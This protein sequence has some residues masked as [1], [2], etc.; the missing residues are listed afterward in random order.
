M[1]ARREDVVIDLSQDPGQPDSIRENDN[2]DLAPVNAEPSTSCRCGCGGINARHC[3]YAAY[4]LP[5]A[6]AVNEA[7]QAAIDLIGNPPA[8]II[9]ATACTA[10]V[11]LSINSTFI[12]EGIEDAY[13]ILK[14]RSLP[15]PSAEWPALSHTK[16]IIA[17][18]SSCAMSLYAGFCDSVLTYYFVHELPAKYAFTQSISMTG[19]KALSGIT[20]G[21]VGMGILTGEGMATYKKT[22]Q[23][24]AGTQSKYANA[25]SSVVSPTAGFAIAALGSCNDAVITCTGMYDVFEI[26]SL[27]GRIAIGAA[28]SVT[29]MTDYCMN[30][31][32]V[33]ECLDTFFGSFTPEAGTAPVYQDPKT[34]AAFILSLAAGAL[35]AYTYHGLTKDALMELLNVLGIDLE[36]LTTPILETFACGGATSFLINATGSI[37]PIFYKAADIAG[38][39]L[40]YIYNKITFNHA[41]NDDPLAEL[42]ASVHSQNE[43]SEDGESESE[44]EFVD[45]RDHFPDED[46]FVFHFEESYDHFLDTSEEAAEFLSVSSD[47]EVQRLPYS[48]RLFSRTESIPVNAQQVTPHHSPNLF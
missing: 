42:D 20:G 16:E 41:D 14:K 48:P 38:N 5:V 35:L 39:G 24:L 13:K 4:V 40:R 22:R 31:T 33:I 23:L 2:N 29:G 12:H 7:T 1:Q 11:A 46:D 44:V 6:A 27:P 26:V 15:A 18:T 19:W 28:S 45:A 34:I 3:K 32:Y 17:G 37:F 30:G 43:T 21:L 25:F 10:A 8:L 47:E 9:A 36:S